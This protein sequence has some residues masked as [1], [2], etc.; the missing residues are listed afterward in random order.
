[1]NRESISVMNDETQP[2]ATLRRD[3]A[4]NWDFCTY[5]DQH[6]LSILDVALAARVRLLVVWRIQQGMPVSISHANQVR[7]ALYRLTGVAYHLVIE[8][9][10]DER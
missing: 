1:M 4:H 7:A 3:M 2:L 5:L 8:V 6:Q 10:G 9:T